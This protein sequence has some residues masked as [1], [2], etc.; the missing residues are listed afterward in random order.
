MVTNHLVRDHEL[1]HSLIGS[2]YRHH[3][4]V[5]EKAQKVVWVIDALGR[6]MLHEL[7]R[8]V[9]LGD[10]LLDDAGIVGKLLVMT[11]EHTEFVVV[12]AHIALHTNP[13]RSNSCHTK[14]SSLG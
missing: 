1:G 12:H 4:E 8:D 14:V 11:D 7:A 13:L 6:E 3:S 10:Q 5:E 2:I 9:S